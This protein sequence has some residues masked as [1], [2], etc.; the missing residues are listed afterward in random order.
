MNRAYNNIQAMLKEGGIVPET[1]THPPVLTC[2]EADAFTPDPKAGLKSLVLQTKS[3]TNVAV[4]VLLGDQRVDF[5]AVQNL[6]GGRV[7]MMPEEDACDYVGCSRGAIP[8]FGHAQPL[9]IYVD[10]AVLDH[11]VVYFNP[12][13]NT[14]TMGLKKDDFFRVLEWH[15]AV[16]AT[17]SKPS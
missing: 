2:E 15:H 8:P 10:N 16:F 7:S 17:I 3:R 1:I 14:E 6:M 12:G 5:K 13:I 4:C 9:A 11:P